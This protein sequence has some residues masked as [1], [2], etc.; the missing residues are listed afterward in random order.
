MGISEMVAHQKKLYYSSK[1]KGV[2][3]EAPLTLGYYSY[4]IIDFINSATSS[5]ENVIPR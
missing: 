3:E 5:I 2:P 4:H 1:D